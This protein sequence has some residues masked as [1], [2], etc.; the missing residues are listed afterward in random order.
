MKQGLK[1]YICEWEENLNIPLLDKSSDTPLVD[2]VVDAW[3]S[4]EVV[5]QIKFIRYEYTEKESEIDV[6]KYL[7]KREKKK[8]KKDRY[9]IKFIDDDRVGR[10]TVYLEITMLETNPSTG[11][12]T[13]QVYPIKKSMLIPIQD[14]HGYYKIKGKNYYMIFQMLEKSTYTSASSITLKSLNNLALGSLNLFNCW[15]LLRA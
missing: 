11:E 5:K 6:N 1:N 3:K 9:D 15:K 4:L 12:T 8:K 2:Y 10:L 13:Y 14:D 7:F